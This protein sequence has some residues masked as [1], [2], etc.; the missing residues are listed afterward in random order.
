MFREEFDL[1]VY[2]YILIFSDILQDYK[3]KILYKVDNIKE[4]CVCKSV[5]LLALGFC[6][7][8]VAISSCL[9]VARLTI[10]GPELSKRVLRLICYYG[11]MVSESLPH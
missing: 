5:C 7:R 8:D 2:L 4:Y 3:L 11:N 9:K 1:Y 6:L 10:Q